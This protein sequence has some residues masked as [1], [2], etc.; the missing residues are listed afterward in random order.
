MIVEMAGAQ[1]KIL[2]EFW[3]EMAIKS[4]ECTYLENW[5]KV[6]HMM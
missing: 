3:M 5:K 2:L 6:R 1:L 4:R